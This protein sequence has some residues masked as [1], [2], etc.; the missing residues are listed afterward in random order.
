M[1][2]THYSNEEKQPRRSKVSKKISKLT[3]VI[4]VLVFLILGFCFNAWH[5]GWVVFLAIPLV[6]LLL[7]IF[8][9]QGKARIISITFISCL[10]GYLLLGFCLKA[11]HPGWLIFFLVPIVEILI[12]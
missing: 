7:S 4:A 3:P 9:R 12:S 5:P 1:N 10:I 6:E 2:N 11:W 8:R